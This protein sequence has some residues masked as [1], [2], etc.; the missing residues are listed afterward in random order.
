MDTFWTVIA[1]QIAELRT[2]KTADEVLHILRPERNPYGPGHSSHAFFA[3]SGGDDSVMEA[4]TD[5]GWVRTWAKAS[6]YWVMRAP[7]GSKITYVEGDVFKGD[8]A[9]KN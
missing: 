5:A 2:A 8:T 4:L 1:E 6:Y 9:I 7:D 3:G